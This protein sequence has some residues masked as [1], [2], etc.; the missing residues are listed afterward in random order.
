MG[1][2]KTEEI[3]WVAYKIFR[4]EWHAEF[5][6]NGNEKDVCDKVENFQCC[7]YYGQPSIFRIDLDLCLLRLGLDK[8]KFYKEFPIHK[9][10]SHIKLMQMLANAIDGD[11]KPYGTSHK[12]SATIRAWME[13]NDEWF[14]LADRFLDGQYLTEEEKETVLH[15]NWIK[16]MEAKIEDENATV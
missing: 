1:K 13:V 9:E 8:E 6:E 5:D 7:G 11:L 3:K 12:P 14:E 15:P 2:V 10:P 4:Q 16:M